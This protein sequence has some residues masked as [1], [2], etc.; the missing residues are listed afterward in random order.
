MYSH[1]QYVGAKGPT[2]PLS[3]T[4]QGNRFPDPANVSDLYSATKAIQSAP[5]GHGE[6]CEVAAISPT[7]ADDT[8]RKME[9][10]QRQRLCVGMLKRGQ[11]VKRT[12]RSHKTLAHNDT[13]KFKNTHNP[14]VLYLMILCFFVAKMLKFEN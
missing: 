8:A 7:R 10:N 3:V 6:F 9:V 12:W 2:F 14:S 11:K 4:G 13:N 5:F 1:S